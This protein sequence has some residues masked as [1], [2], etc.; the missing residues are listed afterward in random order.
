M[1]SDLSPSVQIPHN[2]RIDVN[3]NSS[4]LVFPDHASSLFSKAWPMDLSTLHTLCCS[5]MC[6]LC[7]GDARF[8]YIYIAGQQLESLPRLKDC[9]HVA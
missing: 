5:G 7:Q 9:E 3:T 8:I 4:V 1:V 6:T 2:I